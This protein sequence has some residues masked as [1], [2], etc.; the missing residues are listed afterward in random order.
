MLAVGITALVTPHAAADPLDELVHREQKNVDNESVVVYGGNI[1]KLDALFFIEWTGTGNPVSGHYFHLSNG[2]K[3]TYT[4]TGNNPKDG[5]VNLAEYTPDG[6]GT[7]KL[8]ANCRLTKRVTADR[9]IWEG[10]MNNTDGRVLPMKFS[11]PR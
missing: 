1:G 7:A 8:T 5:V 4:L 6:K 9:I 10:T 11:R 2:R 3:K